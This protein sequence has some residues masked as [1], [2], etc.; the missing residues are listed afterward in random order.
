M[1]KKKI[2]GLA[3]HWIIILIITPIIV[4][5]LTLLIGRISMN[6]KDVFT[7]LLSP[8]TGNDGGLPAVTIKTIWNVRLPRILMALLVGAGLSVAGCAFQS[9]FSNPL[10]TPDTLG[11]ASGSSFGAALGI[12]MG[13]SMVGIQI[14]A[15]ICGGVAVLL[16]WLAGSG[17]G[18]GLSS[19]VLSGIMVGS[20]FTALVSLTKYMADAESQLPSITYWLMGGLDKANF[21]TLS[22][23]APV[24]IVGIV[25]LF[26]LRWRMNLL[27]LSDDEAIASGVNIKR[28]R[29]ITI[30]CATAITASCI[31]MCGQVGWVGLLVPHM[32][33]MKFGNNH[34]AII[35]ASV[36]VGATFMVIVDTLARSVS[37]SEIP[38]SILTAM[39]GAPFF[40]YLMRR[41]GSWQL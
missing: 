23:G 36:G 5:L 9:L 35:P 8:I 22:L 11:V 3:L 15:L 24:I 26:L 20:L 38:V 2:G 7:A 33:R 31:S 18:R 37:A 39:V 28:L 27:P 30:I 40:I 17:K 10:A 41:N 21:N 14:T 16:T 12:L 6:P 19:I 4:A 32:C 25:I 13:F 1:K 29:I 34:L